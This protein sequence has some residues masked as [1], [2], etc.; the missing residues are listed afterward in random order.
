MKLDNITVEDQD[1]PY[2]FR[3]MR[4]EDSTLGDALA[5]SYISGS[6]GERWTRFCDDCRRDVRATLPHL[7]L[8]QALRQIGWATPEV[9]ED[10]P[11]D[12]RLRDPR[13]WAMWNADSLCPP[14]RP[15]MSSSGSDTAT[16][17]YTWHPAVAE[18]AYPTEG[19]D[20]YTLGAWAYHEHQWDEPIMEHGGFYGD[21]PANID[22]FE[23]GA[24]MAN[25]P[26]GY[27]FAAAR[28]YHDY[29]DEEMGQARDLDEEA[30]DDYEE[31]EDEY[32]EDEDDYGEPIVRTC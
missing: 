23:S 18:S 8:D 6:H 24:W 21:Q 12:E 5:Y 16:P 31:G 22:T 7:P 25:R 11:R 19:G 10:H 26:V 15:L 29:P 2:E 9:A 27:D 17:D 30:A 3:M 14:Y 20:L 4:Y 1:I 28:E 13:N 32:G